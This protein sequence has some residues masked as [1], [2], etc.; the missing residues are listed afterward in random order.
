MDEFEAK[1]YSGARSAA[2]SIKGNA[3]NIMGIFEDI[4][5]VMNELYGENWQSTGADSARDRYNQI[6]TKYEVF[7]NDIMNMNIYIHN[8][9]TRYEEA[10]AEASN[11]ITSI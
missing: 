3:Q 8:T 2:D 4:D 1:N 10:D 7:Y 6:R 9:T 5:R 11:T